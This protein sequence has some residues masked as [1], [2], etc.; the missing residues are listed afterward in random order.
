MAGKPP[1]QGQAEA[2]LKRNGRGVTNTPYTQF[3]L[4]RTITPNKLLEI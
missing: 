3:E 1:E 2:V 4:G